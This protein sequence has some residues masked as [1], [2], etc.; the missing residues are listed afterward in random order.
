M[1]KKKEAPTQGGEVTRRPLKG[2]ATGQSVPQLRRFST[3]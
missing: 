2:D 1:H 3:N